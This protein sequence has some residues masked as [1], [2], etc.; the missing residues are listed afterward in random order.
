LLGLFRHTIKHKKNQRKKRV[1]VVIAARNEQEN[2]PWLLSDLVNQDYPKDKLEIIVANDRSSDNTAN[3]V[4]EMMK[5]H[6]NIKHIK[7]DNTREIAPKKFALEQGIKKSNGEIILSTDADCRVLKTWV[8][9]MSSSLDEKDGITIGFSRISAK[10]FFEKYQLI[11]FFC[12]FIANVGFAGWNKYFSG[13]GQNLA[14]NKK[15]FFDIGGFANKEKSISADDMFLVQSISSIRNCQINF[16]PKSFVFTIPEKTIIDFINQRIRWSSYSKNNLYK[17]PNFFL[18]LLS[19]YLCNVIIL[20]FAFIEPNISLQILLA[21]LI[22]EG[23]II[24][25][26]SRL[27]TTKVSSFSFIIWSILQPIY[28]PFIGIAGL[29]NFYKWK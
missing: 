16:N 11:D 10:S 28:I 17:K 18:F 13:S 4:K 27:F 26:G 5:K 9:S 22:L 7:I 21:K 14:Y 29:G 15:S 2:L 20:I 8:T 25:K 24:I 3:I 19:A 1:S 23:A 6:K 12:I